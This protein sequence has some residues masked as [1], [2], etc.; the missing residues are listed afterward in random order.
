[1]KK[2]SHQ[3]L[4]Y[5]DFKLFDAYTLAEFIL[6]FLTFQSTGFPYLQLITMQCTEAVHCV[7]EG[8]ERQ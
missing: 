8:T 2:H 3:E 5:K 6:V 4:K 1:M 7:V